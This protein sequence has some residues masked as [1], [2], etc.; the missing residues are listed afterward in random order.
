MADISPE[1]R[2]VLIRTVYGEANNQPDDGKAAVAHVVLNRM[3]AGKFGGAGLQDVVY[4][5][6]QFEPWM[7]RADELRKLSVDSPQYKS[8]ASVVDKVLLGQA[9]DPTNGAT[10]FLN[11]DTVRAR[12][13]YATAT[14]LPSWAAGQGTRIGAHV[15]YSPDAAAIAGKPRATISYDDMAVPQ[16]TPTVS[17]A[18]QETER[19][20]H[21]EATGPSLWTGVKDAVNSEWVIN[22]LFSDAAPA[23]VAL[24]DPNW[25]YSPE[26]FKQDTQSIPKDLW[27]ALSEAHSDEHR[28]WLL[29]RMAEKVQTRE[30][31]EQLGWTGTGL[32]IAA[33]LLDPSALA[34]AVATEGAAASVLVPAK[35]TR[36]ATILGRA[37][38]GGL[39]GA[40]VIGA[41]DAVDLEQHS[42]ADYLL[43]AGM[44]MALGGTSAQCTVGFPRRQPAA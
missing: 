43:G 44:G 20:A 4:A 25:T 35:A 11:P 23:K 2:D 17:Q 29:D 40:A 27:P 1:D 7:T 24:P 14:G 41:K 39:A 37:A 8:A 10:Y 15:F 9:P 6:N 5:K 26:Q 12:G 30:H 34:I 21:R 18:V 31:L 16:V 36:L 19:A 42:P 3:A 32:Q 13:N 38:S 22:N 33:S 28:N